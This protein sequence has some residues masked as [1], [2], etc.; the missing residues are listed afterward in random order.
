[1]TSANAS[2]ATPGEIF[3]A[4]LTPH[5]SLN[6]R[7]FAWVMAVLAVLST[8]VG[9]TFFLLGA[10]PVPGFLGLDVLA[11][12]LAFRLSYRAG[13]ASEEIRLSRDRQSGRTAGRR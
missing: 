12:Y 8:A 4:V 11:V 1:M 2:P 3:A 10:W 6:P 7:G 5:R 9:S 13:R